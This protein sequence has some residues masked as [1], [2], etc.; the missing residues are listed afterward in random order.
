MSGNGVLIVNKKIFGIIW[1]SAP[2]H[3]TPS[4]QTVTSVDESEGL[5]CRVRAAASLFFS[6]VAQDRKLS[7]SGCLLG[8]AEGALKRHVRDIEV[9]NISSVFSLVCTVFVIVGRSSRPK[10]GLAAAMIIFEAPPPGY[11]V[12]SALVEVHVLSPRSWSPNKVA[13]NHPRAHRGCLP[14]M[15][16][17]HQGSTPK[18]QIEI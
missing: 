14:T 13:K 12:R 15:N 8:W 16:M 9:S 2:R 7:L 4:R 10:K 17:L 5:R 6:L 11:D 18:L 1:K 3:T